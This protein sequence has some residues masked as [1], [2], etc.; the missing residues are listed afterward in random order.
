M[1]AKKMKMRAIN[2]SKDFCSCRLRLNWQELYKET[3]DMS[4]MSPLGEELFMIIH[5]YDEMESFIGS[6]CGDDLIYASGRLTVNESI[7]LITDRCL[8]YRITYCTLSSMI[9]ILQLHLPVDVN[10]SH[11][12]PFTSLRRPLARV[13]TKKFSSITYVRNVV[14][15][16]KREKQS[17]QLVVRAKDSEM[18]PRS[19]FITLDLGK[20]LQNIHQD[21]I[22]SH[23]VSKKNENESHKLLKRFL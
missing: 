3:T 13:V 17:A 2:C 20:Q 18:T 15:C 6:E 4:E 7:M 5:L 22:L 21:N 11:L 14:T 12:D 9:E 10:P 23:N 16:S 19:Y 8:S 1:S